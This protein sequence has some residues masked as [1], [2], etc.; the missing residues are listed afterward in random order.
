VRDLGFVSDERLV[1]LYQ[2]ADLLLFPSH[3]EGFGWPAVEAMACGTPVVISTEAALSETVGDAGLRAP[4]TDEVALADA[5][6]R[7]LSTPELAAELRQRG[8][9]RAAQFSWE[10]TASGYV[11]I[12]DLVASG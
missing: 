2:A 11:A 1:E 9:R 3:H 12:Y 10:R 8:L 4:A 6:A 7:V 5:A